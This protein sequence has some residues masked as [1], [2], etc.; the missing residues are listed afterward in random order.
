MSDVQPPI[1]ETEAPPSVA[2]GA[3]AYSL[4]EN[5]LYPA[6]QVRPAMA[7]YIGTAP[8]FQ[9]SFFQP[10]IGPVDPRSGKFYNYTGPQLV[11]VDGVISRGQ[12]DPNEAYGL[13]A[14]L[15]RAE[16]I[17]LQ[18][19]LFSRGLYDNSKPSLSGFDTQD[20][21]AMKQF[22]LYANRTGRTVDRGILS[23]AMAVLRQEYP[24]V[25]RSGGVRDRL[26]SVED[27][28]DVL[29]QESLR[30]LGR[31]L[32]AKEARE[33]VGYVHAVQT[34]K[35][36]AGADVPQLGLLAETAVGRGRETEMQVQGAAR[37]A[38]ILESLLGR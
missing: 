23:P 21:T 10:G 36:I 20:I 15:P 33:A 24:V 16:R 17:A 6:R 8:E 29:K 31:P 22:L 3:K 25:S 37:M 4:P 19:E 9:E 32:T 5:Y 34:K 38:Q 1:V 26:T 7:A 18:A 27:V 11:D 2:V 30:L 28:Q 14:S 13:L 12:Y 35:Q